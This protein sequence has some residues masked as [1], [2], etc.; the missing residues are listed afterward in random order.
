[1]PVHYE[2][3]HHRGIEADVLPYCRQNNIGV[4]VYSPL[5]RGLLTGK[6]TMDYQFGQGDHRRDNAFFQPKNRRR[7]LE[8]LDNLRPI[9]DAHGMTLA[10]LAISWTL[11]RE[12]I[13][14]ALVGA[15]NPKQV[16]ENAR[17][18]DFKLSDD[19]I[20]RIDTLLDEVKLDI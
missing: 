9:A 20:G 1:M 17:A 11:T 10:Q 18:A 2:V 5:Q 3:A 16:E 6:I 7:V 12:G 19:E 13:T 4:I 15:R 8:L 14:A